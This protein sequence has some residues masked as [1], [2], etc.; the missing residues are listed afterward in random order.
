MKTPYITF[1]TNVDDL[2]TPTDDLR[3]QVRVKPHSISNQ[4]DRLVMCR[5]SDDGTTLTWTPMVGIIVQNGDVTV[6]FGNS[7]IDFDGSFDITESP[8]DEINVAIDKSG[9]RA[10]MILMGTRS[11]SGSD[12]S[13]NSSTTVWNGAIADMTLQLPQEGTW[14]LHALGSCLITHSAGGQAQ[15]R[16]LVDGSGST[17][18]TLTLGT[19]EPRMAVESV[20]SGLTYAGVGGAD[21][22]VHCHLE[23]KSVDA[24][25]TTIRN[26]ALQLI[27]IRTG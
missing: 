2:P 8:N 13:P 21:G 11:Q 12:G 6:G 7:V 22:V 24:G 4:G 17:P 16:I 23:Y 19:E 9:L 1:D 14:Q 27:A 26:P 10:N 18:N 15:I 3:G 20:N 25:T 5:L